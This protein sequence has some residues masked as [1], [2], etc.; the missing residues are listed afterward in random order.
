MYSVFYNIN[1]IYF[2]MMHVLKIQNIRTFERDSNAG[3][4]K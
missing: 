3:T 4:R 1:M 2:T